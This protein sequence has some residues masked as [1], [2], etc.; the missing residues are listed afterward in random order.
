M[1]RKLIIAAVVAGAALLGSWTP[2][3]ALFRT[4]SVSYC[5][6]VSSTTRCTCPGTTFNVP[7]GGWVGNC[8]NLP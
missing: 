2:A 1:K 8:Q 6:T 3:S 7:C 4:C 5:S